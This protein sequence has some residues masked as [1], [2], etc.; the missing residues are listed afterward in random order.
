MGWGERW[1][2]S[3]RG[4]AGGAGRS[5]NDRG[6][7][8][9]RLFRAGKSQEVLGAG[10][11]AVGLGG[12]SPGRSVGSRAPC[13]GV[14][15]VCLRSAALP[16]ATPRHV[17]SFETVRRATGSVRPCMCRRSPHARPKFSQSRLLH[18]LCG[19]SWRQV[20][21]QR[22]LSVG[23]SGGPGRCPGFDPDASFQLVLSPGLVGP[24]STIPARPGW[25]GQHFPT[26]SPRTVASAGAIA[27]LRSCNPNARRDDVHMVG[28]R[29]V[30][31]RDLGALAVGA[32]A[33]GTR[34][35]NPMD[36]TGALRSATL[37]PSRS[38]SFQRCWGDGSGEVAP[39]ATGALAFFGA[40]F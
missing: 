32:T 24:G 38:P 35:M 31:L 9:A 4:R 3:G 22:Q 10:G 13:E 19:G 20:G 12:A 37:C 27:W 25:A 30:A 36:F 8:L 26:S 6:V 7:R 1:R 18:P 17:P 15:D 29:P 33:A 16:R 21:G 2:S 11:W 34:A 40:G 39:G 28:T 14:R 5:R 23:G